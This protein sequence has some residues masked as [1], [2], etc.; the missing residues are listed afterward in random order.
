MSSFMVKMRGF[1]FGAP[2]I[3][4]DTI[5]S[6]KSATAFNA[7]FILAL[8]ARHVTMGIS[9]SGKTFFAHAKATYYAE[10]RGKRELR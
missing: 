10:E 6:T 5:K 3:N 9:R 1:G 8:L 7:I 4:T 2:F